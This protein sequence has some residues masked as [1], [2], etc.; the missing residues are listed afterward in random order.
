MYDDSQVNT[1]AIGKRRK[2]RRGSEDVRDRIE[3]EEKGRK[4]NKEKKNR[5]RIRERR[6]KN[7]KDS[8]HR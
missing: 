3:E 8:I 5:E 1:I 2:Y 7:K 6:G 4:R